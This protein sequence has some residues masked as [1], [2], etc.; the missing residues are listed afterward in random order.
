MIQEILLWIESQNI[1]VEPIFKFVIL[2]AAIK[3]IL[4]DK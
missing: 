4:F 1:W 3:Y 2:I